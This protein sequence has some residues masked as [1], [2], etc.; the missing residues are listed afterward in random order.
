LHKEV[1]L[2]QKKKPTP[3]SVKSTPPEAWPPAQE[4]VRRVLAPVERFLA[5]EAASGIVLIVAAAAALILANSP[6]RAQYES[7]WHI[8]IGFQVGAMV[9]ERELHFWIND[10]LMAIFFFVVGLEI[11]REMY[12]GELSDAR[13]AALPL[14]AAV[15]GMVAPAALFLLFNFN[16]AGVAGWAIPM[17]T[18]IAFAVGVL[19]LL[20]KRVPPA[21][22]ILLLALAVIDD[23]GAILW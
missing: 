17:A 9:F 7:L 21:L 2:S 18:D 15:G 19:A 5:I 8:P 6:L 10:G 23:V 1:A 14:A 12:A 13:R 20:G 11:R 16:G 22:R 4:G 3:E